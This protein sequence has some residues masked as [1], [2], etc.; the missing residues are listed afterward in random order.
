MD[1]VVA[2]I[3]SKKYTK[4]TV[5]GMGAVKGASCQ[6]QSID[7]VDKTTTVTLK[8]E[9]NNGGVHTQSF[10][11]EDGI[12]VTN[13]IITA[14]G[15]LELT[16][17]DGTVIDCGKVLP[18]YDTMPTASATYLN[19]IYQY[20]GSTNPTYTNGY[21]YKCVNDGGTY[22]WVQQEVQ[23]TPV[24]SVNGKVGNII[25]DASDVNAQ[26]IIQY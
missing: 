19:A 18:Q 11:I 8:W 21:F 3:L 10:D 12:D 2:Y 6:V 13:A 24:L 26:D 9:D 4:D 25:L 14:N 17:S 1:G 22:K 16:L 23:P 5:I 15:H 7:K 20:I